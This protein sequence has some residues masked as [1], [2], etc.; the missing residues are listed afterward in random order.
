MHQSATLRG[1]GLSRYSE[2]QNVSSLLIEGLQHLVITDLNIQRKCEWPSRLISQNRNTLRHLKIGVMN[3]VVRDYAIHNFLSHHELPSSFAECA[4]EELPVS[5]RETMPTLSLETLS[6]YGL[7]LENVVGGA[8]GLDIDFNSMTGLRFESCSGLTQAFAL[9]MGNGGA[10]KTKL[11]SL[12]SFIL[13]HEDGS[14]AFAQHLIAFLI[15]LPGLSHLSILLDRCSKA[16]RTEQIL[17]VHGKTLQTLIWEQR[18]GPRADTK[19]NTSVFR[20]SNLK[21]I[22]LNCPNLKALG[23]A[24]DWPSIN[25]SYVGVYATVRRFHPILSPQIN[26]NLA[27]RSKV[28]LEG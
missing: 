8:L 4:K 13:R 12:K 3:T 15:C 14:Q 26:A 1:L 11:G 16:I 17:G 18:T 27:N 24:I 2:P 19:S 28:Y 20:N 6:L 21:Y 7:N 10:Q 23:L 9:L 25:R 22:S 5:E